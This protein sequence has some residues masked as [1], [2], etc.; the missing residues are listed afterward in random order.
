M[1][2]SY[3][4]Y[5]YFTLSKKGY[6]DKVTFVNEK[7][8]IEN[9]IAKDKLTN[10]KDIY[11]LI[12]TSINKKEDRYKFHFA[13]LI[14]L[15][16]FVYLFVQQ[17]FLIGPS[18]FNN[19]NMFILLVLFFVLFSILLI[20]ALITFKKRNSLDFV[21]LFITFITFFIDSLSYSPILTSYY[22]N[23]SFVSKYIFLS[24]AINVSID[25]GGITHVYISSLLFS[26]ILS[27]IYF[28]VIYFI[29]RKERLNNITKIKENNTSSL[30]RFN[31]FLLMLVIIIFVDSLIQNILFDYYFLNRLTGFFFSAILTIIAFIMLFRF[32]KHKRIDFISIYFLIVATYFDWI[33]PTFSYKLEGNIY[34]QPIPDTLNRI[35]ILPF[36]VNYHDISA[37]QYYGEKYIVFISTF[38]FLIMLGVFIYDLV[39]RKK[40]LK[41]Q[42]N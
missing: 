35:I 40:E 38:A 10:K 17:F 2:K 37:W 42:N 32:N 8:R 15:F 30:K 41:K 21:L 4:I 1:K 11:E 26:F 9:A 5:L 18:I 22:G 39:K 33:S 36:F 14:I 3:L 7:A 23:D 34:P 6:Y 19:L 13:I 16:E 27:I 31:P 12:K 28:I 25:G 29:K 20:Y 24:T